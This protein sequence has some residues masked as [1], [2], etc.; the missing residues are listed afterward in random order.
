[1]QIIS[2]RGNENYRQKR[3]A[4]KKKDIKEQGETEDIVKR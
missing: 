3:N 4:K 1:M 2:A